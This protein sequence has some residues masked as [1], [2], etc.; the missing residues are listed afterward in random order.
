MYY[1]RMKYYKVIGKWA[2]L[3]FLTSRDSFGIFANIGSIIKSD[4]KTIW[5]QQK[6]GT[7][8]ESIDTPNLIETL[9]KNKQIISINK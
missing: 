8:R 5:L 9:L 6:D 3:N 4:G 2:G 1:Y 7:W